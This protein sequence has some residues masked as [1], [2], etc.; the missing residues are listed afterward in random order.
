M[1]EGNNAPEKGPSSFGSSSSS[2]T[3]NT[4]TDWTYHWHSPSIS[5]LTSISSSATWSDIH[6]IPLASSIST[7]TYQTSNTGRRSIDDD[8]LS[9]RSSRHSTSRS[10]NEANRSL[11][12]NSVSMNSDPNCVSINSWWNTKNDY[13]DNRN[14]FT[15]S[16]DSRQNTYTN[17]ADMFTPT[18]L[19][20]V[21]MYPARNNDNERDQSHNS[22]RMY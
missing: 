8:T 1:A 19:P 10:A 6:S 5:T 2:S 9:H 11:V 17:P 13:D 4:D 3:L 7:F 21:S 22:S 14:N 16:I 12:E 20:Y 15:T 18:Y